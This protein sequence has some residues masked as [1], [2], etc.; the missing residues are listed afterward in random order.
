MMSSEVTENIKPGS[1]AEAPRWSMYGSIE[2]A[3]AVESRAQD[4]RRIIW[5][6]AAFGAVSLLAVSGSSRVSTR[7]QE[8]APEATVLDERRRLRK[9]Y[10]INCD[11]AVDR[12]R[13]Q[14]TQLSG[15]GVPYER[16][17]CIETVPEGLLEEK[18]RRP[19]RHADEDLQKRTIGVWLSHYRLFQ[20]IAQQEEGLYLVLEDDA[21]L[22][23]TVDDIESA[24]ASLPSDWAYASLNVHESICEEDRVNDD[25]FLKKAKVDASLYGSERDDC[26]PRQLDYQWSQKNILYLSAAAQ[27]LRPSTAGTVTAW[28]DQ[29]PLYHVDA[30]LRT[31]NASV[32]P[33]YQLSRNLFATA[34][35]VPESRRPTN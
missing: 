5:K 1:G 22:Q 15:L 12:Q 23:G 16:F 20:E 14:E 26:T 35:F 32:F 6:A 2:M 21:I 30:L 25:W 17:S 18:Q 9:I 33:S 29:L 34:T 28:L 10:Y 24:A 4:R 27:L 3:E 31:P 7:V 19:P 13:L 8:T 11:D